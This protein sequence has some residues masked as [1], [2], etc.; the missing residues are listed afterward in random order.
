MAQ[1]VCSNQPV[2]ESAHR[3]L[4]EHQEAFPSHCSLLFPRGFKCASTRWLRGITAGL[5]FLIN[6]C[7]DALIPAACLVSPATAHATEQILWFQTGPYPHV[8]SK[9]NARKVLV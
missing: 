5:L 8:V 6:C 9:V 1:V 7:E 2:P 4:K 3:V